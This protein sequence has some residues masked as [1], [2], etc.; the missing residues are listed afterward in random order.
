M[1][2]EV[3]DLGQAKNNSALRTSFQQHESGQDRRVSILQYNV[4][5]DPLVCDLVGNGSAWKMKLDFS[6]KR[7]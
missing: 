4:G 3:L 6:T 2:L 7:K 5:Q 1:K